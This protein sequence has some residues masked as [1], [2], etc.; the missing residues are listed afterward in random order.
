M[1]ALDGRRELTLSG[2]KVTVIV[3]VRLSIERVGVAAAA[4]SWP[5]FSPKI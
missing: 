4:R 5:S 3:S 2:L 1:Y